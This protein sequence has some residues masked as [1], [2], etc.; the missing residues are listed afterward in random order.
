MASAKQQDKDS[1]Y[2]MNKVTSVEVV[3]FDILRKRMDQNR[4]KRSVNKARW[5][6]VQSWIIAFL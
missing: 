1:N 2:V 6:E 4:V 3:E 5:P